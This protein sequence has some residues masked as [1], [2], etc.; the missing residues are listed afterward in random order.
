MKLF[1]FLGAGALATAA[2]KNLEI[3]LIDAEGGATNR[4]PDDRDTQAKDE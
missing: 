4:T 3:Y 1:V 2:P